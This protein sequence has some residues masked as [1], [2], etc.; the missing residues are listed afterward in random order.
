M[1]DQ[2]CPDCD[3]IYQ[4]NTIHQCAKDHPMSDRPKLAGAES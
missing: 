1:S 2:K 4:S 3:V